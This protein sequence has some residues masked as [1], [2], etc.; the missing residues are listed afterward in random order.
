MQS[1]II[2]QGTGAL[3]LVS[4]SY[5][6]EAIGFSGTEIGIMFFIVI[7][8]TIPGSALGAMVTYQTNPPTSMKI[9]LVFFMIV[10]CL[11]FT[12]M[13]TPGHEAYAYNFGILWGICLGWFYPTE[14][15]IFSV[16]MPKGQEAELAGFFLYCTQIFSW[17]PPLIFTVLN[18][19]DISLNLAGM[20]LNIY[21]AIA[22]FGYCSMAPWE[23]CIEASKTNKM[24][25]EEAKA[26]E[27]LDQEFE[28]PGVI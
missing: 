6:K 7:V 24:L 14:S 20:H 27:I 3:T 4:V 10:N 12:M 11:A 16:A 9:L 28:L 23:E 15:L 19:N 5:L 26:K 25:E 18:E 8:C 1:S 13:R 17:V 22:L 2:N 21:I